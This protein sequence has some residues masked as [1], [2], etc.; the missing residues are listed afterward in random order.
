MAEK[1]AIDGGPK[2]RTEPF[3]ERTPYGKQEEDLLLQA[4]RSQNLFGKSGTFV[5]ALEEKFAAFYG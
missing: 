2:V 4:V 5:K 1:L 3:P